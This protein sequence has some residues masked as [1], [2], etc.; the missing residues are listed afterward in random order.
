M[1]S[2]QNNEEDENYNFNNKDTK[3][4]NIESPRFYDK[5]KNLKNEIK[6]NKI[7]DE[8]KI[9]LEDEINENYDLIFPDKYH[10]EK[11]KLINIAKTEDGKK[12]NFYDKNKKE[13]IFQSGVRKEIYYDGY[14]IIYFTNGDIKQI[15]PD[16][17]KQVYFFNESKI[18]QTTIP[19]KI[20]VFKFQNEQNKKHYTTSFNK[21]I[22]GRL[23]K[24]FRGNFCSIYPRSEK[25]AS[26]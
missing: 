12:I 18:I 10:K 2:L 1:Q 13:I 3:D 24:E 14:Q 15:F 8:N 20:Q 5:N 11:Y 17:K 9:N 6:E 25:N 4:N 16:K 22:L 21:E 26:V 7:K 19:D 23:K